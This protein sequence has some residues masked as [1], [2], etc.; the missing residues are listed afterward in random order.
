MFIIKRDGQSQQVKF[1]NIS[2][3][4]RALCDGL[5]PKYVDPVFVAQ[6]VIEGFYSGITTAEVD[7]L[8]HAGGAHRR[9]QLAQDDLGLVFGDVPRTSRPSRSAGPAGR[10]ALR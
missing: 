10:H 1:D 5:D 9:V 4:I 6:K 7:G 8:L 2:K 3:R